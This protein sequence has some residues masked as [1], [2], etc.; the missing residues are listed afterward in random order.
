MRILAYYDEYSE[1]INRIEKLQGWIYGLKGMDLSK[2]DD[3]SK[4][5]YDILTEVKEAEDNFYKEHL[6][7]I[8]KE[9][10]TESV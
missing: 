4:K 3:L 6:E 10:E 9:L 2:K 8:E 5:L 7:E 1:A